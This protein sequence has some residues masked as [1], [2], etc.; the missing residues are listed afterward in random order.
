MPPQ[1]TSPSLHLLIPSHPFFLIQLKPSERLP[2]PLIERLSAPLDSDTQ[3]LSITRT[4]EEVSI[5]S[6]FRIDGGIEPPVEWRCIRVAGPMDLSLTGIMN[7]LTTPLKAAKIQIFAL[8]T[9]D[10]DFLLVPIEKGEEAI[11]VMRQ[12]GWVVRTV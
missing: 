7:D 9:W 5:V 8:S 1:S 4:K 12:D 10:T 6:D 3:F 2:A 11:K